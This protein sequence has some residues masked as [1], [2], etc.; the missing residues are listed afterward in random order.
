MDTLPVAPGMGYLDSWKDIAQYLRR[1][2]RTVQRWE[3]TKG[4][5]VHRTPGGERPG[6]WASKSELDDWRRRGQV[7]LAQAPDRPIAVTAR[8]ETPSVAVLP[9]VNISGDKENEYFADGLADE[10]ITVLSCVPGL[11]VTARTSSFAFRG[12]EQDI[13]KIGSCLGA[14]TILEGAVRRSGNRVRVTAQLIQARDGYHLWSECYD[15]EL[16]ETFAI[17]EDIARAIVESLRLRLGPR[18]SPVRHQTVNPEAYRLW[19]QGRYHCLRLIPAEL[20]LSRRLFEQAAVL[21]PAFPSAQLGIAESWWQCACFGMENA[22]EAA[23]IGSCAV[24]RVLTAHPDSG[25]AH[26]LMGILAGAQDFDWPAAERH[27]RRALELNPAAADIHLKYA[28]YLL[29]PLG[30]LDEAHAELENAL[31]LDPLSPVT[32]A[33]LGQCVMFQRRY[34]EAVEILQEAAGLDPEFW[35]PQ[36]L[37]FGAYAFQGKFDQ[38]VA[39]AERAVAALGANPIVLGAVGGAYGFLGQPDKAQDCLDRIQVLGETRYVSPLSIAWIHMG[40]FQMEPC[41]DWLEK[42][43]E[44]RDP[45][46]IHFGVKPLY[47]ALRSHPRF[48]G[49]LQRMG[50]GARL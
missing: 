14:G 8:E 5:P 23:A 12:T 34:D 22:R 46:I 36:F 26:A 10:I 50:L 43:I 18:T 49:L 6:V 42:A 9:F 39:I 41:L 20:M 40:L 24:S 11:R 4:L 35:M 15:R 32:L 21:D 25:E 45:Q 31:D 7:H 47:D 29:E 37:L 30:R 16:T 48:Q 27:F 19:L 44:E 28:A 13:R 17:Q 38:S 2:V 3:S 1:D 33:Y